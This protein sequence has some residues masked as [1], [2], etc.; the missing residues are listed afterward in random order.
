MKS[1]L[2]TE[3]IMLWECKVC[4]FLFNLINWYKSGSAFYLKLEGKIIFQTEIVTH[5]YSFS[6]EIINNTAFSDT[7]LSRRDVHLEKDD[8]MKKILSLSGT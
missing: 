5:N 3:S 6:K 1:H 4:F 2:K 7:F 8:L